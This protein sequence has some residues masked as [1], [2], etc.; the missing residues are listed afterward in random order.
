MK[1]W[2]R[3]NV[4]ISGVSDEIPNQDLEGNIIKICEDL[5]IIVSHMDIAGCH[6][7][8]LGRNITNTTKQ[9]I[10]KFIEKKNIWSH[11][12]TKKDINIKSQFLQVI[13]Y[14][15]TIDICEESVKGSAK[16]R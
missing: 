16:E 15:G 13:D 6:T 8:P 5:D 11:A 7:V 3:S 2:R 14:A 4:K 12:S 10:V 1:I 9:L